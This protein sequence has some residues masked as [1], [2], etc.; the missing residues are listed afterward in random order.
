MLSPSPWITRR[1]LI[2]DARRLT[3]NAVP[4]PPP[5]ITSYQVVIMAKMNP[6]ESV[7]AEVAGM[8][9][10]SMSSLQ[11]VKAA[12]STCKKAKEAYD[13]SANTIAKAHILRIAG[14]VDYKLAVMA[15]TSRD[16]DPS[17]QD[18]VER[19][20]QKYIWQTEEW[21]A[22]YF[23]M[24]IANALSPLVEAAAYMAKGATAQWAHELPKGHSF[25][26]TER[27]RT[28][29]SFFMI[30]I[31]AN[32]FHKMPG[33]E[34]TILWRAPLENWEEKYWGV[35]SAC[36]IGQVLDTY[37]IR[38]LVDS[39]W[40][41][42]W[43]NSEETPPCPDGLDLDT[44]YG[45]ALF[46][47]P[48][49]IMW[50]DPDIHAFACVVGIHELYT[51]VRSAATWIRS[52]ES[53]GSERIYDEHIHNLYS[54]FFDQFPEDE[55]REQLR[56]YAWTDSAII[57]R[58]NL[59]GVAKHCMRTQDPLR[60]RSLPDPEAIDEDVWQSLIAKD[61]KGLADFCGCST[62]YTRS[63]SGA[64]WDMTTMMKYGEWMGER[65]PKK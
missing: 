15:V 55:H 2:P 25:S 39:L 13:T 16:V 45:C 38:A 5:S 60:R 46:S 29:N 3:T 47:L 56:G 14:C 21:P 24:N 52:A 50:E 41:S 54:E 28:L 31:A 57:E 44:C 26:Q 10:G 35:F 17:D 1:Y 59:T 7:P 53:E 51:W 11:D 65:F 20:F 30:E 32:L 58:H 6:F 4:V 49:E 40:G 64:C 27:A 61:G 12:L 18:S 19:F 22:P 62:E 48:E 36:E 63:D 8:I 23:S 33:N 34:G 43:G 42:L 9:Y 37:V